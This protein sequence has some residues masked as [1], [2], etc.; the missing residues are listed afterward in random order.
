M[1]RA[2][3]TLP[4]PS[5]PLE[6][7]DFRRRDGRHLL[8]LGLVAAV[9][10]AAC[11]SPTAPL[12]TRAPLRRPDLVGR[13]IAVLPTMAFRGEAGPAAGWDRAARA[14]WG[15]ELAGVRAVASDRVRAVLEGDP[16]AFASVRSRL[17]RELPVDD[18]PPQ[19]RR[20]LVD[21]DQIGG[22]DMGSRVWVT[23]RSA[24]GSLGV[25]P[26]TLPTE[27][28]SRFG[29]D[30]VLFSASFRGYAQH[31]RVY[32]LFAI[33]PYFGMSRV[34]AQAPRGNV[35]LYDARSGELVWSAYVGGEIDADEDPR[36]PP[37]FWPALATAHLL[38]GSLQEPVARLMKTAPPP[39]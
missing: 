35:L 20:T 13:S 15:T 33:L 12:T 10:L 34:H 6:G 24:T 38:T 16:Q 17:M 23:I 32:A 29:A 9:L 1:S 28:L 26:P 25:G 39:D 30:Y 4:I 31:N 2:H 18:Q 3:P 8:V 5:A 19:G 22:V 27:W 37:S 14:I 36:L 11:A 7:S 21:S